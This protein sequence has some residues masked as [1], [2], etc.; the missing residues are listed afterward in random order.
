[1]NK[2]GFIALVTGGKLWENCDN[3]ET[4]RNG[5]WRVREIRKTVE[6]MEESPI[7][8]CPPVNVLPH[9]LPLF[10]VTV[11]ASV[12]VCVCFKSHSSSVNA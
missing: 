4:G 3:R 11:T 6:D 7:W 5:K 8:H 9:I 1:M 12:C 10:S 2:Q